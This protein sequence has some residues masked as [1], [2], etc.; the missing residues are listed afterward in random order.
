M[1][2]WS[3]HFHG[4]RRIFRKTKVYEGQRAV[5]AHHHVAGF[6]VPMQHAGAVNAVER[7][8]YLQRDAQRFSH[9]Q[10]RAHAPSQVPARKYSMTRYACSSLTPRSYSRTTPG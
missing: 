10:L 4:Q 5:V 1:V 9:R 8:R 6:Q 3:G 7:P 2:P